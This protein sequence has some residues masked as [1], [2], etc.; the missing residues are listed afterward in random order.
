MQLQKQ[1][2][3]KSDGRKWM[4]HCFKTSKNNSWC[5]IWIRKQINWIQHWQGRKHYI[6]VLHVQSPVYSFSL[7]PFSKGWKM[8]VSRRCGALTILIFTLAESLTFIESRMV[9]SSKGKTIH[10]VTKIPRKCFSELTSPFCIGI[11]F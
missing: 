3:G 8:F 6:R 7:P 1:K 10:H 5:G 9:Q 4:L 11:G 2:K